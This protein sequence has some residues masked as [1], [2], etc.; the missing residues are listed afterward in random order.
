MRLSEALRLTWNDTR[1]Q[2]GYA[3]VPDTKN[4]EPRAVFLP[5]VAV[6]A[7]GNLPADRGGRP[8]RFAKSGHLYSLLKVAA[9]RAGIDLPDRSAFHVLR[10]TYATWMRRYAGLD[11]RGLVGTGAWKDAKSVQRYVHVVVSE[12]AGRAALLP[13]P[14]RRIE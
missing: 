6:A 13:T 14:K 12:E 11:E 8:F 2:D 10:H 7:L 1:L 4:G 9:I 5:P 3:Y